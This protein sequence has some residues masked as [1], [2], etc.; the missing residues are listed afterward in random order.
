[1][2]TEVGVGQVVQIENG[3]LLAFENDRASEA[4]DALRDKAI[5]NTVAGGTWPAPGRWLLSNSRDG[6][7]DE[8][9]AKRRMS[10]RRGH[11]YSG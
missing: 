8:Q 7:Q 11:L 10:K 2:E 1:V 3:P 9:A 4:Q 6:C 5:G